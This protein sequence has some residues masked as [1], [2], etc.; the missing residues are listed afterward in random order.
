MSKIPQNLLLYATGRISQMLIMVL[1]ALSLLGHLMIPLT[2]HAQEI[3]PVLLK[4]DSPLDCNLTLDGKNV[5]VIPAGKLKKVSWELGEHIL[6][7][8]VVDNRF[9]THISEK[10][11][12]VT[13]LQTVVKLKPYI[14]F[15][16]LLKLIKEGTGVT[17]TF[18]FTEVIMVKPD[19]G[20]SLFLTGEN[21]KTKYAE[22][23]EAGFG[24]IGDTVYVPR[25]ISPKILGKGCYGTSLLCKVRAQYNN[26]EFTIFLDKLVFFDKKT[27]SD[28][29]SLVRYRGERQKIISSFQ[30]N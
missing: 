5:G 19:G 11:I 10:I 24:M 4:C 17:K 20:L 16:D 18:G 15:E 14:L 12:A 27:N 3:G 23:E 28:L 7:V 26:V 29:G 21:K 1:F 13:P 6:E 25:G 8:S 9:S 22:W 2:S 30:K